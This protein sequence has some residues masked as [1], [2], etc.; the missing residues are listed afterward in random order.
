MRSLVSGASPLHG[1]ICVVREVTRAFDFALSFL[2]G[3]AVALLL[4]ACLGGCGTDMPPDS[5]PPEDPPPGLS[6]VL[7]VYGA[8]GWAPGPQVRWVPGDESCHFTAWRGNDGVCRGGMFSEERPGEIS[9]AT[10]PGAYLSQTAAA[11]ETLHWL[12]YHQGKPWDH[13]GDFY[14]VVSRANEALWRVGL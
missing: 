5:F 7:G 12:L 1:R 9:V 3:C 14:R 11:H 2:A 13:G 6:I 4:A 10:W 8:P